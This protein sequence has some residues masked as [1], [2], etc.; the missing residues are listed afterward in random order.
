MKLFHLTKFLKIIYPDSKKIKFHDRLFLLKEIKIIYLIILKLILLFLI[1]FKIARMFT[2]DYIFFE[3]FDIM[4][5]SKK[6]F[7]TV[8]S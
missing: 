3:Q 8:F 5:R 2:F 1:Q 4:T 6:K 7:Y